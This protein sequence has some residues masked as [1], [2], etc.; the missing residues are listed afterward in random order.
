MKHWS[1]KVKFGAFATVLVIAALLVSGALMVPVVYLSQQAA[2]DTQLSSEAEELFRDLENF[3][4][5]PLNP[6]QPLSAKFIPVAL[7]NRWIV[8][9]GPE[10]QILYASPGLRGD[11]WDEEPEGLHTLQW[12][13][14]AVRMGSFFRGP[15][16]LRIVAD[17]AP[18]RNLS[19]DLLT[20]LAVA[21]P[22]AALVVF[23]GGFWLAAYAIRPV[24]A[25]TEAAERISVRRLD[26]RLPMPVAQDEIARLTVVLNSAFDRLQAAYEAAT[27]FSADAS[28]QLKTPLSVL[29]AGLEEWRAREP[30]GEEERAAVEVLLRQVRRLTTLIEDLL[31][32]AQADAGRLRLEVS[33][34]PLRPLLE[35]AL[36]DLGTL[37]AERAVTIESA[38]SADLAVQADRRRVSIILQNL[39]E[40]AAKYTPDGGTVRLTAVREEER[41]AVRLANTGAGIAPDEVDTIFERFRRG[42]AQGE[43]VSGH[44][45]GLNIARTLARAHEGDLRLLT[46]GDGWTIFELVLPVAR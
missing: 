44:G 36:D 40:N 42:R 35:S 16:H 27:R 22:A 23:F 7:L 41:V 10:G 45:L 46:P 43:Q 25:L 11:E 19:K 29:R 38:L 3:R 14:R 28:H 12:D 2:L 26:E 34:L 37:T 8:L 5:A 20:G 9:E 39:F 31:L 17:L 33:A 30:A 6:R 24:R 32:L 21:V 15:Y 13:G 18:L 1:L 4:G